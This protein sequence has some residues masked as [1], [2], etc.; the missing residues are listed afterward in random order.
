MVNFI[1]KMKIM[2]IRFAFM[3][4]NQ[5]AKLLKD[6]HQIQ[7]DDL[8]LPKNK[9][10]Y[11][12]KIDKS[13]GFYTEEEINALHELI[14]CIPDSHCIIHGDFHP[15]NIMVQND[16]FLLIDMEDISY[17]HPI[18]DFGEIYLTH[19]MIT[20]SGNEFTERMIGVS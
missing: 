15:K 18:F 17:G 20:Q 8:K 11:H 5:Y 2:N 4:S 7:I 12:Q 16:E 3:Y 1:W 13:L 6:I 9:D 14:N 19:I 10:L